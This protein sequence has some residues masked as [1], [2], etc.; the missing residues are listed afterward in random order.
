MP[1]TVL[2]PRTA[3]GLIDFQHGLLAL[4]GEQLLAGPLARAA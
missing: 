1:L 4:A 2:D 3:L